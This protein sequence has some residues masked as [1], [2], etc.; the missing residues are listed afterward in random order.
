MSAT[1]GMAALPFPVAE[2]SSP[3]SSVFLKLLSLLG[4]DATEQAPSKRSI[5]VQFKQLTLKQSLT[6]SF[7]PCC[8]PALRRL[9]LPSCNA[10]LRRV[11]RDAKSSK[12][13]SSIDVA[14]SAA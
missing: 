3:T 13:E 11:C 12:V 9:L 10:L 8:G 5:Q 4:G 1:S 2:P 7:D 14:E 6:R